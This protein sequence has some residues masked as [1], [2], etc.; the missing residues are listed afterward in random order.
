METDAISRQDET[1]PEEILRRAAAIGNNSSS[2]SPP[3]PSW[4]ARKKT[5]QTTSNQHFFSELGQRIIKTASRLSGYG[6]L[7]EVDV[8]LRPTGRSGALATTFQ[9]FARYF[10]EGGGQL[11]ERQALCK[12]R[13]VYGSPRAAKAAMAAVAKAAFEPRW[14]RTDSLEIRKMRQRLE[15][16]AAAP[17]DLKRGPGGIVDIEF[18]VQMLQL[19]HGREHPRIRAANTLAALDE[20][21]R[22]KLLS[23]DACGFFT[24]SYRLLRTIEGR[25]RLM[26]ST[27]RDQLPDDPVELR[28]LANLLHY[29]DSRDLLNDFSEA[30]R[31]I[32][33]RFERF[34]EG[35]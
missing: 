3:S 35:E 29:A 15:D 27:A 12:A 33:L 31:E 20:L 6:R 28:K 2:K 18:L 23:A 19:K 22:A 1:G 11:W 32:R 8:R 4:N 17:G 13:A 5:V 9:E 16:S 30:T 7:Y 24:K 34:F 14:S 21:H 10:S 25:L 26:N